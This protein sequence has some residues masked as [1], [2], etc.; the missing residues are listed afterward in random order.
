MLSRA[1]HPRHRNGTADFY[2]RADSQR[3]GD[4]L[5][6]R[7]LQI[8][9]NGS[10][11][12]ASREEQRVGP[13]RRRVA[14]HGSRQGLIEDVEVVREREVEVTIRQRRSIV[15]DLLHASPGFPEKKVARSEAS[16]P[17]EEGL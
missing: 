13:P 3:E 7:L 12:Q 2:V 8:S 11:I 16:H 14:P 10:R 15:G 5:P 1:E 6:V 4:G 9:P 17:S